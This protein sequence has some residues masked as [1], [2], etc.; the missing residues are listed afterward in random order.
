[1]NVKHTFYIGLNDKDSK[2]QLVDTLTAARI[3]QRVFSKHKTDCT[4]TNGNGVYT[5]SDGQI[6]TEQTIIVTVFEFG[7]PVNV[8][9]ICDDLKQLLNQESIAVETT[10]TNS[11]LY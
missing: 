7:E 5:H 6:T 4:I 3:V 10:E 9:S 1:M 8:K 11:A 2:I